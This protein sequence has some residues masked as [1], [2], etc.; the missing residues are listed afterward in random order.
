VPAPASSQISAVVGDLA[1][2]DREALA[3]R[4]PALVAH[5]AWV[6]DPRDPR[7]VR[8]SLV[9]LLA[10]AV[11][12]TIAGARSLAAIA[13]WAA[14]PG[15]PAE[16]LEALQVRFDPLSRRFEV[17]DEA[18][19]RDVLERLDASAFT[20]AASAWL[21]ELADL[22]DGAGQQAGA[23]PPV[24]T[25]RPKQES[26]AVDGK[27]LRGTRHHTASGRA[28]H[29]LAAVGTR[30]G[31]LMGQVEVDGKTSELSAFRPLLES[32]D[33]T[34]RVETAD[35]LHTQRDHAAFLVTE[36]RAHFIL[37]VKKNQRSL[38]HQLKALPW[39]K[40]PVGHTEDHHGHGRTERRGIKICTLAEGLLFPHARQAI[41]ITRKVR[42]RTGGRWTTVTV[43][44]VTSLNAHQATA[45]Q[46]A[47]WIRSHWRIEALH[48]I[49]DVT[50]REDH[51]QIRTGSGPAVMAAM[52]SLAFA[53]LKVCGWTNI[54]K[55]IRHHHKDPRRCLATLGLTN[56]HQ[57]R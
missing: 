40:I 3:A 32:L 46:I 47:R 54:A 42:P 56:R 43:Y 28:R 33:L 22:R 50:Y 15:M 1:V 8:H 10:T 13:E 35:A 30:L 37:V 39:R 51:S 18:T 11:A 24:R 53:I 9:S 57:G 38:Y 27:A 21:G 29:L 36:K 12:A 7:G 2:D 20:A 44:A 19:F 55:A 31:R 49:R 25:G 16:L 41:C 5:L 17:P 4:I 14:D 52:R 26:V 23:R 6:P 48:H 45:A 34:D